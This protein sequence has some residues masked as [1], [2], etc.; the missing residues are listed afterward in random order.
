MKKLLYRV[1]K[2]L[3]AKVI[4]KYRPF[5]IGITGSVGKTSTKEAVYCV[6]KNHFY[7]RQNEKN[8]NNEIGLPL[9]I[10]G[11]KTGG[12][13]FFK[14][15]A[16]LIKAVK[17]LATKKKN[18]PEMLVLE[19]GA[20]KKGDLA[21][22]LSI[23]PCDI[24]ILTAVSPVHL[25][26]F[27]SLQN[28]F[29]EKSQ[30]ITRLKKG[31]AAIINGD[32][33]KLK[34][35]KNQTPA[36]CL[37]YGLN[38]DNDLQ[39]EEIHLAH[40]QNIIGTGFKLKFQGKTLPVFLPNILGRPQVYSVLAA[41]A[42]AHILKVDLLEAID[43][44]QRYCPP[45]GRTNLI[46]GIKK[47]QLIDD[48]YNAS[49]VSCQM[50]LDILAEMPLEPG[51]KKVAVFGE[52][53]ELGSYSEQGHQEVGQ[54][55]AQIEVDLL[56]AVGERARDILRGAQATGLSVEKTIY[57]SNNREAGLYVQ[58]AIHQ[59]DIVLIK[60][61]QGSRMEQVTKELMA[62]PHLANQLLVRQEDAWLDK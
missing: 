26:F 22:L 24:G 4:K 21:Y 31:Q 12:H 28:V 30:I 38:L 56:V 33:G 5:I 53:L 51:A 58:N 18:Y 15:L 46:S 32:D 34:S 39:A 25:E 55:A 14:W 35:L 60:G 6:L 29:S 41:V 43:N 23:A 36:R 27:G 19:M 61:S 9:T 8:Y 10:L 13:S 47:T 20:D 52:M 62:E 49:P 3:A 2:G 17:L 11:A 59:G 54:K 44:L 40:R 50:A 57:F 42:A 1:L 7:C 37:S 45:K 48:T 16:V